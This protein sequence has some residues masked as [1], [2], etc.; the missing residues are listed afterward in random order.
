MNY[1]NFVIAVN[2]KT[3]RILFPGTISQIHIAL[4]N[5]GTE[6]MGL[7]I[8]QKGTNISGGQK[9]R[10]LISRAIAANP[11]ILILDD[12]SSALDYKTESQ[13]RKALSQNMKNTTFIKNKENLY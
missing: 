7:N 10:I 2:E 6:R 5:N 8:S 13:L 3:N 4:K 9:Q 11:E 12:S 1:Q